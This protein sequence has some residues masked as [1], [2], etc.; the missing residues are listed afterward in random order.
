MVINIHIQTDHRTKSRNELVCLKH[1]A[2]FIGDGHLHFMMSDHLEKD[3][4]LEVNCPSHLV[5]QYLTVC[6]RALA[7]A[8]ILQLVTPSS[9]KIIISRKSK[10]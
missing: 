6:G 9:D 5:V 7:K 1:N 10:G 2:L 8:V 3:H 4:C